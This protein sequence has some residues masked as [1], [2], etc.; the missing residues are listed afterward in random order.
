[1]ERTVAQPERNGGRGSCSERRAAFAVKATTENG[2]ANSRRETQLDERKKSNRGEDDEKKNRR[3]DGVVHRRSKDR[4]IPAHA[5]KAKAAQLRKKHGCGCVEAR[6]QD[7]HL[8][9]LRT[10]VMNQRSFTAHA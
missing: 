5:E 3:R 8:H 1:M 7:V 4:K 6:L 9:D 2:S 10:Q